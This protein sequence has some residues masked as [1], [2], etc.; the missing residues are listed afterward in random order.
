M[1]MDYESSAMSFPEY[2]DVVGLPEWQRIEKV[3][4]QGASE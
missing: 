1:K 4:Q 3:S 2:L